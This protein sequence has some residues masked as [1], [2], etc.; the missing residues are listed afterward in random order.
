MK[1]PEYMA[2]KR[3]NQ[4]EFA[5]LIGCTQGAISHWLQGRAVIS[6]E[7]AVAIEHATDGIIT[8]HDLRPDLFEAAK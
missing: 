3:L 6:A 2:L 7:N 1:I 4:T 8:A 5:K